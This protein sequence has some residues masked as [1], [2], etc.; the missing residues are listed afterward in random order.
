MAG[1]TPNSQVELKGVLQDSFSMMLDL[2]RNKDL[3]ILG[4]LFDGFTVDIAEVLTCYTTLASWLETMNNSRMVYLV[5]GN[6]DIGKRNDRLS[7]FDVLASIL[8]SRFPTRVHVI[9]E[10]VVSRGNIHMI[11]HCMNQDLFNIE[12]E[13]ARDLEPG[14]LLLHA[15]VDNGFAEN[16]DHSLNVSDDQLTLLCQK[17][18]VLFAHEHQHRTINRYKNPVIVLGN[19]WPSSV[20]DCL[21]H[22]E[23]QKDGLKMAHVID[24]DGI[25]TIQTWKRQDDFEQMQWDAL[26]DSTASFI[27]ITGTVCAEQ[28]S[29]VISAIAKYRKNS[30]ALVITNGVK[31]EGIAGMDES[32][33]D[34][35][36]Q[37]KSFDVLQALLDM[38]EPEERVVVRDLLGMETEPDLNS[39]LEAA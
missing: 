30:P 25:Q 34:A 15:N 6:H 3:C 28:A 18:T 29:D 4:D 26:T 21:A 39:F 1:T 22:G 27:R 13:K 36:T 20:A 32:S 9:R 11:P 7:S 24:D 5:A 14:Y 16:S 33:L 37:V 10:G 2:H 12:L 38:L 19:Q 17:H 23:A 8:T 31:V 35:L